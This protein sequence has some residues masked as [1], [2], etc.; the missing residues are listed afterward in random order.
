MGEEIRD[1]AQVGRHPVAVQPHERHQL[2]D[3]RDFQQDH[4]DCAGGGF[5]D[6][7]VLCQPSTY[8]DHPEEDVGRLDE[9][10][11]ALRD[12]PRVDDG[13]LLPVAGEGHVVG[14]QGAPRVVARSCPTAGRRR[15]AW[16]PLG[17][18][19]RRPG[20]ADRS[21][22]SAPRVQPG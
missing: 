17:R 4:R 14:C 6:L 10:A 22:R 7:S 18:G 20:T 5:L 13:G 1:A 12:V 8:F 3:G 19:Q 2:L 11:V 16:G 9:A 15:W 21:G